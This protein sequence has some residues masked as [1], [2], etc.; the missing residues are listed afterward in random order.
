M[1]VTM[2]PGTYRP[3][4]CGV[5]DYTAHLRTYLAAQGVESEVVTT[6]EAAALASGGRAPNLPSS[7]PGLGSP[8]N[9]F[10]ST[11]SFSTLFILLVPRERG[12]SGGD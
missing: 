11:K 1:K 9:I 5:A 12:I 2:I 3:N 10:R 7:S 4:R 8:R 6:H